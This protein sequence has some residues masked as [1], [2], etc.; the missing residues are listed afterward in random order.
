MTSRWTPELLESKVREL[1]G[2]ST[3]D[4]SIPPLMEISGIY[5]PPVISNSGAVASGLATR[6]AI[7]RS[8]GVQGVRPPTPRRLTGRQE[9]DLI[10][11]LYCP[12]QPVSLVSEAHK[13]ASVSRLINAKSA[14]LTE[15]LEPIDQR[16]DKLVQAR[17]KRLQRLVA[18]KDMEQARL[19]TGQPVINARSR[20]IA[21]RLTPERR[22]AIVEQRRQILIKEALER[23]NENLTFHP[24]ISD[25]RRGIFSVTERLTRDAIGRRS[26]AA[27]REAARV[28]ELV[29]D[30]KETPDISVLAKSMSLGAPVH[31]RL[32]H[33]QLVK[34]GQNMGKVV[35]F[36]DFW[37][38][39]RSQPVVCVERSHVVRDSILNNTRSPAVAQSGV[40]NSVRSP[41]SVIRAPFPVSKE[42]GRRLELSDIFKTYIN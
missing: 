22:Q 14:K 21:D 27:S 35:D 10:N 19:I 26:R 12:K 24:N 40:W 8:P 29:A 4:D 38:S 7:S 17:E 31:D 5:T 3:I 2:E 18:E 42:R 9:S 20:S 30:C 1:L 28:Q 13:P 37:N 41:T 32:Y 25:Q 33:R 36:N 11:R 23:E 15:G 6:R 39:H 16:T 34:Q